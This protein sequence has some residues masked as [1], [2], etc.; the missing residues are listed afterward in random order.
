MKRTPRAL[1]LSLAWLA[2]NQMTLEINREQMMS[3]FYRTGPKGQ[4]YKTSTGKYQN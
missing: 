3:L 2:I 4:H 1:S